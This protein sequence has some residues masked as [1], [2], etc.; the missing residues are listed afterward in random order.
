MMVA[1]GCCIAAIVLP[2]FSRGTMSPGQWTALVFGIVGL[3]MI[4]LMTALSIGNDMAQRQEE[5]RR[6]AHGKK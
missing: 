2:L 5:A 4:A 6:E 3:T 1:L